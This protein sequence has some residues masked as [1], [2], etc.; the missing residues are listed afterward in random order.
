[1]AQAPQGHSLE[2]VQPKAGRKRYNMNELVI[3]LQ[4][5]LLQAPTL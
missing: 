1:M 3:G 4:F 2:Y 5:S